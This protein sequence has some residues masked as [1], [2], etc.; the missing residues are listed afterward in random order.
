[1]PP[2]RLPFL[3]RAVLVSVTT[4]WVAAAY[5][6]LSIWA[7]ADV[8]TT[9]SLWIFTWPF[10]LALAAATATHLVIAGACAPLLPSPLGWV[11]ALNRVAATEESAESAAGE[12]L[13][14]A[15]VRLPAF[16][17]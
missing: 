15:L 10:L 3:A 8:A 6:A 16:P 4:G 13:A 1:M 14:F 5:G 7:T 2:S 11:G 17:V 12:P 9:G